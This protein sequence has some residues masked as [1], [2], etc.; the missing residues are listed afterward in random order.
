M[1][2]IVNSLMVLFVFLVVYNSYKEGLVYCLIKFITSLCSIF[3]LWFIA[4]EISPYLM[5][6]PHNQVPIVEMVDQNILY[7]LCNRLFLFIIMFIIIQLVLILIRPLSKII[8]QI[9][10]VGSL[11]KLGGML[12]GFL[13]SML[14]LI[15]IS[16]VLTL[17]IIPSGNDIINNS[18]FKYSSIVH[19][20]VY[21]NYLN[22]IL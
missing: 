21:E 1:E 6:Y 19:E 14:V 5:I 18:W 9:P 10:L 13:E 12:L 20:Y 3:V 2:L 4:G 16:F 11:N 22:N 15:V 8:N 7:E 17:P